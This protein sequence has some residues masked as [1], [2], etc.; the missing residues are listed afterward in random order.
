MGNLKTNFGQNLKRLRKTRKLTQ[1]QLA[2][3]IGV[4]V[5]FISNVERGINGPSFDTL[6]KLAAVLGV[7]VVELFQFDE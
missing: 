7:A 4:S 3:S 1:E 5:D 6:E 2:E